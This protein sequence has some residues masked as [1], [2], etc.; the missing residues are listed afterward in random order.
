MGI[1]K[2]NK[3]SVCHISNMCLSWHFHYLMCHCPRVCRIWNFTSWNVILYL[4]YF[5]L[6]KVCIWYL[7]QWIVFVSWSSSPCQDQLNQV[8]PQVPANTIMRTSL[9]FWR[10]HIMYM[11]LSYCS[12]YILFHKSKLCIIHLELYIFI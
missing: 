3:T 7:V 2:V 9:T 8:L 6:L 12:H 10:T 11:L 4:S 1:Y 5:P